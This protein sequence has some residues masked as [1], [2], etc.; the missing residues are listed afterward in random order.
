LDVAFLIALGR[1]S[2]YL[3][4]ENHSL[5]ACLPLGIIASERITKLDLGKER[6]HML[7]ANQGH[8]LANDSR[9]RSGSI[10]RSQPIRADR[11]RQHHGEPRYRQGVM[12]GRV[13]LAIDDIR[14]AYRTSRSY[15]WVVLLV[16]ILTLASLLFGVAAAIS[17]GGSGVGDAV[18][19]LV[20]VMVSGVVVGV[21]LWG[22]AAI[23]YR[24]P[25][26]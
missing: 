13:Q 15:R 22:I 6:E 18:F 9:G 24:R 14:A 20:S 1:D 21:I 11:C 12:S 8:P 25:A 19:V 7:T 5:L 23:W 17:T 26:P 2:H 3:I 10:G 4:S 16:A